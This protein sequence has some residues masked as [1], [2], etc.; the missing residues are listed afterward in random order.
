M[1]HLSAAPRYVPQPLVFA[2]ECLQFLPHIARVLHAR[3]RV[4]LFGREGLFGFF[5]CLLLCS[6]FDRVQGSLSEMRG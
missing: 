2:A 3:V 5:F 4:G 1:V 6:S